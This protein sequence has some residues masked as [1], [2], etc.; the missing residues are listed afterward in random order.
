[1]KVSAGELKPK[2][3]AYMASYDDAERERLWG[4]LSSP[5]R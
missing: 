1:L 5:L 3:A 2:V 4:A